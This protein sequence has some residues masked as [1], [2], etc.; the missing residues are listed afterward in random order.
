MI[1]QPLKIHLE[2]K[3]FWWRPRSAQ[4]LWCILYWD[5]WKGSFEW[6]KKVMKGYYDDDAL[7]C[8]FP[9]TRMFG[10][11]VMIVCGNVVGRWKCVK[12]L[13]VHLRSV[14]ML[15]KLLKHS[16]GLL[17]NVVLDDVLKVNVLMFWKSYG[18]KSISV[19][20]TS[21]NVESG[22]NFWWNEWWSELW[23][24]RWICVEYQ[25]ICE[26]CVWDDVYHVKNMWSV[27]H[28]VE[29]V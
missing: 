11:K 12:D 10:Y 27:L 1:S 26:V 24:L 4:D 20:D 25:M 9:Q 8:R 19:K 23:L 28:C 13:E 29:Y 2:L 17:D 16:Y 14:N 7:G 3:M 21:T 15:K 6:C 5:A 22:C 18:W